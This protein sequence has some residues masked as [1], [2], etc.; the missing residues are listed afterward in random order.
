[1]AWTGCLTGCLDWEVEF[2]ALGVLRMGFSIH[3]EQKKSL[4][5]LS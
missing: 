3:V 1:M 4:Y 5:C 2:T